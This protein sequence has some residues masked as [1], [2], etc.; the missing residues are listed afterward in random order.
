MREQGF[1]TPFA[2]ADA[3]LH[4]S[5]LKIRVDALYTRGLVARRFAVEEEVTVSDHRPLWLDVAWPEEQASG[6]GSL[7]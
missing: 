3:T 7:P 6:A 4:R 5:L 2:Q 1:Q